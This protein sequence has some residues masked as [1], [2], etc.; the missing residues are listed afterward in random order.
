MNRLRKFLDDMGMRISLSDLGTRLTHLEAE[1]TPTKG[2][3]PYAQLLF[4]QVVDIST[5][6]IDPKL[7]VTLVNVE[8]MQLLSSDAQNA[9]EGVYFY[10]R[11]INNLTL[12]ESDKVIVVLSEDRL[13][14]ILMAI[15]DGSSTDLLTPHSHQGFYDGGWAGFLSGGL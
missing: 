14:Y 11:N 5:A 1:D 9:V 6:P 12:T 4:A 8:F 2:S 15:G 7:P 13:P 10:A 3:E